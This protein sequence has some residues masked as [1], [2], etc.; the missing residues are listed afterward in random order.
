[1]RNARRLGILQPHG[2][3]LQAEQAAA[4]AFDD[5]EQP[6]REGGDDAQRADAAVELPEG[7]LDRILGIL[8]IGAGAAGEAHQVGL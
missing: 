4:L 6:A 2:A 1:M 5:A 8:G 3:S 7:R